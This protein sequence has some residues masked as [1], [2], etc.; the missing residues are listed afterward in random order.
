MH[1]LD[2]FTILCSIGGIY[3]VKELCDLGTS[4]NLMPKSIIKYL[5]IGEA[6]LTTINLQLAENAFPTNKKGWVMC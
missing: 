3:Y 2:N 4:I 6:R 1:I 5:R